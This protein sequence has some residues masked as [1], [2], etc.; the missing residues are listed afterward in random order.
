MDKNEIEKLI[1][2]KKYTEIKEHIANG[3]IHKSGNTLYSKKDYLEI[4]K[5]KNLE[6]YYDKKQMV[7][8]LLLS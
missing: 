5:A 7:K 8:K 3:D 6:E 2:N 1:A 4:Q